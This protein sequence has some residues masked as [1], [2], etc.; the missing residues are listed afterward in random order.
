MLYCSAECHYVER[1]SAECRG[2]AKTIKTKILIDSKADIFI[3]STWLKNPISWITTR[4]D[5]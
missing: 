1:H 5:F 3:F 4:L 2:T